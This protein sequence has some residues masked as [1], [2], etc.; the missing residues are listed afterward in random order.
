MKKFKSI[1]VFML[2]ILTISM[3]P[4]GLFAE[5]TALPVP[6]A[7]FTT[8]ESTISYFLDSLKENDLEKAFTACWIDEGS[9][10]FDFEAYTSGIRA[11][12]F[13]STMA[14]SDYAFY[15]KLNKLEIMARLARQIKFFCFSLLATEKEYDITI[16][17]PTKERIAAF[18]KSSNPAGL[19]GLEIISIDKPK[20]LES[21]RYKSIE[22][23]QAKCFGAQDGTERIVLLKFKGEFY[24]SGF[25]LLK[26][27]KSWK[28]DNMYSQLAGMS[29]FGTAE[30]TDESEYSQLIEPK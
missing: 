7:N 27:K 5:E 9:Q 4:S 19:S 30:K 29:Y 18:I 3:L 15:M 24:Y 13:R 21:E 6:E 17:N 26:Y 20:L 28:I 11:I 22:K 25:H 14:P 12:V 16:P 10:G 8:P 2:V 23:K 1:L